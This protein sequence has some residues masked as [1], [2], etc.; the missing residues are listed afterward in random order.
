[1]RSSAIKSVA[2]VESIYL[3]PVVAGVS[4]AQPA[5]LPLHGRPNVERTVLAFRID[6]A[7]E[8]FPVPSHAEWR[9]KPAEIEAPVDLLQQRIKLGEI[10]A[11]AMAFAVGARVFTHRLSAAG[12]IRLY[13]GCICGRHARRYTFAGK[14]PVNLD[15]RLIQTGN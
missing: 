4:P 5:R 3:P 14:P 7:N 6:Q 8:I 15:P 11:D 10:G 1:M 2:S 12:D 9:V 13:T